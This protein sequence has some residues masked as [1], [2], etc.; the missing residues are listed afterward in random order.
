M[1]HYM[2]S[3]LSWIAATT[4]GILVYSL[5]TLIGDS[6]D[7]FELDLN[8]TPQRVDEMLER[9]KFREALILALRLNSKI[10]VQKVL[11]SVPLK[12]S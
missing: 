12:K 3:G 9:S 4:E 8:V 6:F 7:P 2:F 1:L 10:V 11:E 5:R